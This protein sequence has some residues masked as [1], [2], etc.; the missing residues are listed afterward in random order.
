MSTTDLNGTFSTS[1]CVPDHYISIKSTCSNKS[2][3]WRERT[4]V[5]T[6]IMI[7]PVLVRGNS[8]TSIYFVWDYSAIDICSNKI[9]SITAE[10][11]RGNSSSMRK[12]I[13]F[14]EISILSSIN[15]DLV[16]STSNSNPFATSMVSNTLSFVVGADVGSF[17]LVLEDNNTSLAS[18]NYRISISRNSN[19][20]R[21]RSKF[22]RV[23]LYI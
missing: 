2:S 23:A 4:T 22:L 11:N 7:S 14:L 12:W 19:S 13:F 8:E 3:I 16:I 9:F 18:N 20:T 1:G 10:C 17:S 15:M 5:H 21:L 6:S